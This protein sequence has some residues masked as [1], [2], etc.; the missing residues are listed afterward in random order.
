MTIKS[1]ELF[2]RIYNAL[3]RWIMRHEYTEYTLTGGR[4][5]CKSSFISLCIIILIVM[6]PQFNALIIRKN[7][8]TLRTSVY[9]QIVWAIEKLGLR[10]RFKIPK[11]E[12]SALPIVYRRKN[13][14]KQYIIFRGCDDP[15]K[16]KSLKIAQGYFGIIWFE[17]KT[18]FTPAEIQNVK[19]SAMRGGSKFYVFESYNP[20]SAKRHWCNTDARTPKKDRVVFHTTYLDIP[21]EW[22]GDAILNEIEHTKNTNE[23]AYRNIF[24]GEA[25]G[26]GLNIFENIELREITDAEIKEFEWVYHGIDWG[27]YPDP[28]MWGEMA[29]DAR[30]ATLY[31]FDELALYKHGN[32]QA[33]AALD[34]KLKAKYT[35]EN[36]KPTY[37][38][39]DDY[40]TADS[41]EPKSVAD[42]HAYGW[43][44]HGAN[45]AK[46]GGTKYLDA[47]F[48]WLQ[49][50]KKIV[51][52]PARCPHAADEF[53]LY[54]YEI[55]KRTGDIMTGYPQGQPDHYLALT[56]Y[57]LEPVWRHAGE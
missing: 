36:G 48:K 46:L 31:I 33:S 40:I 29:Y 51:I 3:F 44:I 27:Y 30:N 57:A 35:G 25:T 4:G 6:F 45:K 12:T 8:N 28:F 18:E 20:P 55:D 19:V 15:E 26:T 7:A 39:M 17:E 42:F 34:K 52:D 56:R 14:T 37:N 22:L 41:A 11:S 21:R 50:L 24:L 54:E 9:E 16:I 10:G 47:G 53:T 38:Y 32:D 49:S 43:N 5:S 2:A 13:G 23:R 1:N